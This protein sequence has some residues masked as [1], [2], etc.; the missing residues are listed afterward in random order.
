MQ[1]PA[2]YPKVNRHTD[3]STSCGPWMAHELA[4]APL[5]HKPGVPIEYWLEQWAT[6]FMEAQEFSGEASVYHQR[7]KKSKIRH[8]GKEKRN[9]LTLP[10]S[11]F[12]KGAT[13]QSKRTLLGLWFI[14]QRKRRVC[15]WAP[16][17]LSYVG[18]YPGGPFLS[19]LIQHTESWAAWLG[20][21]SS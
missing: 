9:S 10:S 5:G 4:L 16:G 20:T 8:I 19:G 21:V 15:E 3:P 18:H 13:T 14:P 1:N 17:S 2:P 12:P 7:K 6:Y 11:N